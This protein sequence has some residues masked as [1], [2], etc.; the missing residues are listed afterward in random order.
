MHRDRRMERDFSSHGGRGRAAVFVLALIAFFAVV[1][2]L[3]LAA[4]R[5]Q[6]VDVS[7]QPPRRGPEASAQR[8]HE[9]TPAPPTA[10]APGTPDAST[11]ADAVAEALR[12]VLARGDAEPQRA[13]A[14]ALRGRL[15]AD[16]AAWRAAVDLLLADATPAALR[17]AL[18]LIL[19]TIGDPNPDAALRDALAKFGASP[20]VA[21]AVLLALGATREPADDDDVFGFGDRPWGATGP[22][23]LGVT[24][25][26][27]IED[28]TTRGAVAGRLVDVDPKTRWAAATALRHSLRHADA[29]AAFL[30][31]LAREPSDDV[32]GVLGE[33]LAGVARRTTDADERGR[34]LAALVAR[35]GEPGLDGYRFKMEDEF[36]GVAVP[37]T[38]RTVLAT[39]ADSSHEIGV[40]SFALRVLVE[41]AAPSGGDA[42]AET[43]RL[44]VA[45]LG[46]DRDAAARDLA[47]RRLRDLPLD[48]SARAALEAAARRDAAWNVRYTALETFAQSAPSDAVKPLLEAAASD[49]D[50][51]V[52]ELAVRLAENE[53]SRPR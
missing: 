7:T 28:A 17:E 31:A 51:R 52:R 13:A 5:A 34:L 12:D 10:A 1:A 27:E 15:R 32:A 25:R 8:P 40:R 46:A 18:A 36:T 50:K 19:G 35:A 30:G 44:L 45:T 2:W 49:A 11:P 24:V 47:A 26:R 39:L 33:S 43:T 16:P 37:V 38:Q 20:D 14:A 48:D 22:G 29:G 3:L 53:K 42:V 23:A 4:E 9:R 21:R 41:T 6:P